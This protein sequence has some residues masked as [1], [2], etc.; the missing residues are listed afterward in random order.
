MRF[1][2]AGGP[3][4]IDYGFATGLQ[5]GLQGAYQRLHLRQRQKIVQGGVVAQVYLEG[6]LML[7]GRPRCRLVCR[8][9]FRH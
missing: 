3:V 5:L 2:G 9:Y 8:L 7:P 6:Q 4:E 1:S